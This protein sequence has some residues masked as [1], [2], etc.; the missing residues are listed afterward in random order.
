MFFF[1]FR[2]FLLLKC[3]INNVF[4]QF[5]IFFYYLNAALTMFF[6]FCFR[7]KTTIAYPSLTP[8]FPQSQCTMQIFLQ[9]PNGTTVPVQIPASIPSVP[10]I[11]TTQQRVQVQPTVINQTSLLQSLQQSTS[12]I[13]PQKS[14]TLYTKQVSKS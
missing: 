2:Y 3:S 8:V 1:C 6:F 14:Q 11:Q 5:Q 4:F 7:P 12:V 13:S 10:V 9:L